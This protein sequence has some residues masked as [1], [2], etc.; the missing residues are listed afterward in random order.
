TPASPTPRPWKRSSY[1]PGWRASCRRWRRLTP[2]SR[3]CASPPGAVPRTS[4][5]CASR[6]EATR[7]A[8]RWPGCGARRFETLNPIDALFGRLRPQGRKA[9]IPFLTAGDPDTACTVRLARAVAAAGADL[10]E[11]GFPYSDPIADG[12]VIQASYTR[13][14]DRGVRLDD[15]FDCARQ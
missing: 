10:L 7:T 1:A 6:V 3:R 11:I 13:A 9:F 5:S 12:P 8:S 15:V 14:L 4:S 2:S